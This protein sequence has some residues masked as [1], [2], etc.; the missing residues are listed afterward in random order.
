M[1]R[2]VVCDI[3]LIEFQERREGKLM[4]L[5]PDEEISTKKYFLD[6]NQ[7][8]IGVIKPRYLSG[9]FT[10]EVTLNQILELGEGKLFLA[11]VACIDIIDCLESAKKLDIYCCCEESTIRDIIFKAVKLL[12]DYDITEIE[13]SID[14]A[15]TS[16]GDDIEDQVII[17]HLEQYKDKIHIL[18]SIEK[19]HC[20]NPKDGYSCTVK[21]GLLLSLEWSVDD[22]MNMG[23]YLDWKSKVNINEFL[24]Y[25]YIKFSLLKLLTNKDILLVIYNIWLE[26][27]IIDAK[28]RLISTY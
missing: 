27:N 22:A 8:M 25:H 10:N 13:G 18:Q 3:G 19:Q 23:D 24:S 2:Q 4:L 7:E 1:R 9:N 5:L 11:G 14:V 12:Q 17:F 15:T 26:L 20:W 28:K 21:A 6:I 16:L